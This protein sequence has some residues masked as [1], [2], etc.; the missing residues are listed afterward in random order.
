MA[1]KHSTF[2]RPPLGG[3]LCEM[4]DADIV[5]KLG[6]RSHSRA[7]SLSSATKRRYDEELREEIRK[8]IRQECEK[9]I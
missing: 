1:T 7:S 3:P 5:R 6:Q 4:P 9:E 2:G 8:E